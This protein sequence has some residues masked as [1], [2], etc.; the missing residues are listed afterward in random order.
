MAPFDTY[1]ITQAYRYEEAALDEVVELFRSGATET[2][3]VRNTEHAVLYA[4]HHFEGPPT[5]LG[6]P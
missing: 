1:R 6:A 2:P 3:W 5:R 4:V